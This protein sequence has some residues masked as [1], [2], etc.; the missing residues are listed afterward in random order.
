MPA[1]AV[2]L[3]RNTALL[4]GQALVFHCHHYNCSLQKAIEDILGDAAPAHLR[5][6][7]VQVVF[8]QMTALDSDDPIATAR[9]I[10]R[11]LGFGLVEAFEIADAFEVVVQNSHYSLGWL[12]KY[13]P[14]DTPCDHFTAGFLTAA[15]AL[16]AN[17]PH[18]NVTVTQTADMVCGDT[19]NRYRVEVQR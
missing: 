4:G 1:V 5:D 19:E 3:K 11:E 15:V 16:A 2:D 7:A 17:V 18:A 6:A 14:R 9:E 13:G 12:A 8:D 10:Y